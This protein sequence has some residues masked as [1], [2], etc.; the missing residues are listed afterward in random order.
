M[1]SSRITVPVIFLIAIFCLTPLIASGPGVDEMMDKFYAEIHAHW[2]SL[3]LLFRNYRKHLDTVSAC[4]SSEIP[5]ET[6][7]CN[8]YQR[9]R[10]FQNYL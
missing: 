10:A 7:E 8:K 3:L 9:W 2:L 6:R 4:H 1:F 5:L